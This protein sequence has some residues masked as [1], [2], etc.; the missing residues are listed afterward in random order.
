[1]GGRHALVLA[2]FVGEVDDPYPLRGY[3]TILLVESR[4]SQIIHV[5]KTLF[6]MI[7]APSSRETP[8]ES[9]NEFRP[10]RFPPSG[11]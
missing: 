10:N 4:D 6:S 1:M 3:R 5:G 11:W 7:N 8:V 9:P 2:R